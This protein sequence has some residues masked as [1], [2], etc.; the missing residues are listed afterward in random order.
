M[1]D[2]ESKAIVTSIRATSRVALKIHENFYTVE[3][4]E[5]RSIPDVEGVDVE[6]ERQILW[7]DVNAIVDTQ[8]D[9]ILAMLQKKR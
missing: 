3:H 7:D 8:A 4:S 1:A 9:D 6:K 2:Y 5:E